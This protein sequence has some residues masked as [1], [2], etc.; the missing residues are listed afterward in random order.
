[1]KILITGASGLLGYGIYQ[2]LVNDNNNNIWVIDNL[3][4]SDVVPRRT[5]FINSDLSDSNTFNQLP[6][7]FDYIYHFAAINGTDRFYKIPNKVLTNNFISDINVFEFA[8]SCT[9][10]K[11]L[12]YASSS[13]VVAEDIEQ[14][15][16][17]KNT[18][19]I[20]DIHNARWSYRLAKVCSENYLTN[21][22]LPWLIIRY[23]NV[24]SER[25]RDGHFIDD[26]ICKIQS[27]EF[28]I[29][30]S[31][32]Y[33]SYC[34]VDDAAWATVELAK[35]QIQDI[36]NVG[37]TQKISISEASKTI[38]ELLGHCAVTWT[39]IPGRNGSTKVRQPNLSKLH[40]YLPNYKPR[41][42]L[43]GITSV[44]KGRKLL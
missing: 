6:R 4:R 12:I 32:E 36:I 18:I 29:I 2:Q 23:F 25:S 9:N 24:Y 37:N 35:K 33:R 16:S 11:C 14:P 44:L 21:S 7:D 30:G 38:A 13:E 8:K 42:F 17:E 5:T 10:L 39:E 3:S 34:Y 15:V 28:S 22:K 20:N 1:M 26:Q 41:T 27:G 40:N 43:D 31:D 19:T